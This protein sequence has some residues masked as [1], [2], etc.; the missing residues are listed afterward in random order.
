MLIRKK[1]N[2]QDILSRNI[3]LNRHRKIIRVTLYIKCK[4]GKATTQWRVS[5]VYLK[6]MEFVEVIPL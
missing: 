1:L 6:Q 4:N 3:V 2:R 5:S